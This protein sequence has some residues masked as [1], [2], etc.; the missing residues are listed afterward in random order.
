MIARLPVRDI[1][2]AAWLVIAASAVVYADEKLQDWIPDA[3]AIPEDAEVVTNRSVGSSIRLL[4]ITTGADVDALFAEWKESLDTNGYTVAQ[5]AEDMLEPSIE[6]TGPDIFNAKIIAAPG[7][8][9][10][11]SLIEFDATLN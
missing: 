3:L 10:G 8:E 4:S 11:R 7:A 9:D 2:I 6:F 5:G 1:L